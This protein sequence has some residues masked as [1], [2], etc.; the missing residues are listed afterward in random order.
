MTQGPLI[1]IL[2]GLPF[3][4]VVS[5]PARAYD[6]DTHRV[7]DDGAVTRSSLDQDPPS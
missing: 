6:L 5:T 4:V 2:L 1:S 3:I 7:I